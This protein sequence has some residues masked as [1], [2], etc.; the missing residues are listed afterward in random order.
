MVPSPTSREFSD[1]AWDKVEHE[2]TGRCFYYVTATFL[3]GKPIGLD[4]KLE[5]LNRE[6]RQNGYKIKNPMILIQ[7]G[8]MKGR[9]MMEVEKKDQYDA[10]VICYD[11]QTTCDTVVHYGGIS[12]IG[13][14]I[15]RLKERVAARRMMNPREIYYMYQSD[16]SASR[17]IIF[18]LT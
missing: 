12:S 6:I 18:A 7:C 13:K 8:K 11:V 17:T 2:W 4:S 9:I 16:P 3:L 1:E 14:G 15:E 10:Q 5:E